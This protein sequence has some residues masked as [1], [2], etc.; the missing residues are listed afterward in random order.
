MKVNWLDDQHT[1][2]VTSLYGELNELNEY[3]TK[4]TLVF[5]IYQFYNSFI[6]KSNFKVILMK[7]CIGK[8]NNKT[9]SKVP[10]FRLVLESAS[11]I[12]I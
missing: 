10:T 12:T 5:F 2:V 8:K 3:Y 1:L 4:N 6:K 7:M 11:L 9:D